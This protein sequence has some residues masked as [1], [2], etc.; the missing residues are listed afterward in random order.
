MVSWCGET[1]L[2]SASQTATIGEPLAPRAVLGVDAAW[3]SAGPS[4]VAL[5]VET[6]G[7]W[8]LAAVEASYG[9]FA[10]RAKGVDP[11]DGRPHGCKPDATALL[12]AAH[13]ICGR[14]VDLVAVDMPLSRRPIIGRRACDDEVSRRYGAK[15]AGTHSPSHERPGKIAMSARPS[16]N[17]VM[18]FAPNRLRAG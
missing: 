8:R 1:R 9:H 6:E 13:K 4:G 3:T 16:S 11:G 12:D 18:A 10:G 5:A 2:N 15:G 7:G 14:P 17:W